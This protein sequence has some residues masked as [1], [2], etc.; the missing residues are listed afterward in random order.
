MNDN[1]NPYEPPKADLTPP[2]QEVG[3]LE[4]LAEAR[5]LPIGAGFGWISGSWEYVKSNLGIWVLITL[6]LLGIQVLLSLVPGVGDI[7]STIIGPILT[8]GILIGARS[9]DQGEKLRFDTLFA[10][11]KQQAMPLAGLGLLTLGIFFL[12]IVLF[13]GAFAAVNAETMDAMM[14]P[15]DIFSGVNTGLIAVGVIMLIVVMM[16]FW[17]ATQLV[18]LNKVPVFK[19]LGMS[20]K[21]CLRNPLPLLVYSVVCHTV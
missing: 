17:F 8:G 14:A 2:N 11:F 5:S 19:A 12:L 7:V 20:F 9:I 10:G 21:A 4:L 16:L 15:E 1:N 13:V 18:A 6:A 3:Q